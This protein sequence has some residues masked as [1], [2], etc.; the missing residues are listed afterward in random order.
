M[1]K[2]IYEPCPKHPEILLPI[3]IGDTSK[4]LCPVCGQDARRETYAKQKADVTT[5]LIRV[6]RP[7]P[8]RGL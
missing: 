4:H 1:T 7:P 8:V 2:V 6:N 3:A 5:G